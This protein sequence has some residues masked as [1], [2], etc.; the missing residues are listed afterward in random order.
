[1]IG[2]GADQPRGAPWEDD[3]ATGSSRSGRGP[4]GGGGLRA[5]TQREKIDAS[6]LIDR[7]Y[8]EYAL[9]RLGRVPTP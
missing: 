1:V 6:R 2:G 8:V 7:S 3:D 5:G 9:E 4:A